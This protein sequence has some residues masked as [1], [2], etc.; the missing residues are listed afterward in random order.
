M[1][2]INIEKEISF[3]LEKCKKLEKRLI[4]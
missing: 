1:L 4:F 3:S 2:I